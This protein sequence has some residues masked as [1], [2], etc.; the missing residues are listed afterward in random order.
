[1]LISQIEHEG[2]RATISYHQYSYIARL[3]RISDNHVMAT[4]VFGNGVGAKDWIL[5]ELKLPSSIVILRYS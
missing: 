5:E 3:Q 1:M 2:I 4:K